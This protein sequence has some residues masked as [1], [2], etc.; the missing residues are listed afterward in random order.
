MLVGL[1]TEKDIRLRS[2][3]LVIN[4]TELTVDEQLPEKSGLIK[5]FRRNHSSVVQR[6]AGISGGDVINCRMVT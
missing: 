3:L 4:A 5:C 2:R 1:N 6:Y